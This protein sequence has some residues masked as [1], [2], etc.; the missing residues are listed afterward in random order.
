ME[1]TQSDQFSI[2]HE[3]LLNQT[4]LYKQNTKRLQLET[5][6]IDSIMSILNNCSD[7]CGLQ[8]RESGIKK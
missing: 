4:Q 8:Y 6:K 3:N 1:A 2:Q 5:F 7:R